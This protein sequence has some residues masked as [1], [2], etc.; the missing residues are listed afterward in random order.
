M[1]DAERLYRLVK[2]KNIHTCRS[3]DH[4][5]KRDNHPQCRYGFP[6]APNHKGTHLDPATQR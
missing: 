6:A 5:C 4:G 3:G 2:R 1:G